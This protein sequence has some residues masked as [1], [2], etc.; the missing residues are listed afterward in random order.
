M[1]TLAYSSLDSIHYT[2]TICSTSYE[3]CNQ[4]ENFKEIPSTRNC[5]QTLYFIEYLCS[6]TLSH[7]IMLLISGRSHCDATRLYCHSLSTHPY[8][9][10]KSSFSMPLDSVRP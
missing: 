5:C 10:V 4:P 8:V 2:D 9:S 7:A 3:I 1:Y 6:W